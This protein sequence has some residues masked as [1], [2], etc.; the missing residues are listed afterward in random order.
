MTIN[1]LWSIK[2]RYTNCVTRI[3]ILGTCAV[4]LTDWAYQLPYLLLLKWS[5]F[6]L[7]NP[8]VGKWFY[9]ES[10]YIE[11]SLKTFVP[12]IFC[13]VFQYYQPYFPL[14]GFKPKV[15]CHLTSD[16]Q[17]T[18]LPISLF[19][20]PICELKIACVVVY[21]SFQ[22]VCVCEWYDISYV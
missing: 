18:L 11:A 19:L 4:W 12:T 14:A 17:A 21:E 13:S 9:T 15:I 2:F 6:T 1:A 22:R 8:Q 10:A 20:L 16:P 7:T 5:M 3:D